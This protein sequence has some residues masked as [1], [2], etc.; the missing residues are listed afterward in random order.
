MNVD[1][2]AGIRD[3]IWFLTKDAETHHIYYRAEANKHMRN[4]RMINFMLLGLSLAAAAG[5][6]G[7]LEIEVSWA[8][9][10]TAVSSVILFFAIAFL[11]IVFSRCVYVDLGVGVL[12]RRILGL[13]GIWPANRRSVKC[14]PGAKMK[15]AFDKFAAGVDCPLGHNLINCDMLLLARKRTHV[16]GRTVHPP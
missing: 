14:T 12:N 2:A 5:L 9:L 13:A 16:C 6:L 3:Q 8:W 10:L 4:S 7:S 11:T 1:S 15:G